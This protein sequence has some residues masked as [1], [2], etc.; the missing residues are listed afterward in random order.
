MFLFDDDENDVLTDEDKAAL[1]AEERGETYETEPEAPTEI[2]EE[3]RELS[4]QLAAER[5]R[6][7]RL[8][9]RRIAAEEAAAPSRAQ[10]P[11]ALP[12]SLGPRPDP[13]IDPF[14]ADIWDARR[15]TELVRLQIEQDQANRQ[16]QEFARWVENDASRFK[17]QHS[18]YDQTVNHAYQFRVNYWTGLGLPEAHARLIADREAA[19]TATLARQTGKSAAAHFYQLGRQLLAARGA[20]V[21]QRQP[22]STRGRPQARRTAVPDFDTM[23]ESQLENEIRRNPRGITGAIERLELGR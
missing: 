19:A 12:S 10:G 20:P 21:R 15:E 6:F 9:E 23:S 16:Q 5:E 14:G 3:K 8:D 4:R 11:S 2:V 17:A 1:D 13:D 7:A 18:D 22:A